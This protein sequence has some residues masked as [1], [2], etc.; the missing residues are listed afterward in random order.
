MSSKGKQI[1]F[2]I[3]GIESEKFYDR[4]D[5]N[6]HLNG[7]KSKWR[8]DHQRRGLYWRNVEIIRRNAQESLPFPKEFF[9]VKIYEHFS[10]I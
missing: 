1:R 9:L 4:R 2:I 3:F 8:F 10:E 7:G 6:R 5:A